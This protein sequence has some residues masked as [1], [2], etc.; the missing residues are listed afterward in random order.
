MSD[1]K[2]RQLHRKVDSNPGDFIAWGEYLTEG[3]RLQR[4]D[5]Y[6]KTSLISWLYNLHPVAG[7]TTQRHTARNRYRNDQ[8][9][10]RWEKAENEVE[11]LLHNVRNAQGQWSAKQFQEH[12]EAV[13]PKILKLNIASK[14][15]FSVELTSPDDVPF[16]ICLLNNYIYITYIETGY[17][18]RTPPHGMSQP[19]E[20]P[21]GKRIRRPERSLIEFDPQYILDIETAIYGG[22]HSPPDSDISTRLVTG[23]PHEICFELIKMVIEDYAQQEADIGYGGSL[24]HEDY[25]G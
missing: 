22:Y 17:D 15:E 14:P 21:P 19:P 4:F 24:E 3:A 23:N 9:R 25:S 7:L 11:L 5:Q 18:Q 2:L 20:L 12:I 10:A 16:D 1:H 6:N 13:F 8:L